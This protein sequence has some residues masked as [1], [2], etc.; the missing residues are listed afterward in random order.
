MESSGDKI[1][2]LI[3][4]NRWLLASQMEPTDARKSFPCFDEPGLKATFSISAIHRTDYNAI[5]N[6]PVKE[7][8]PA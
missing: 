5:S 3:S 2:I 8:K 6:M 1:L 7:V 4:F